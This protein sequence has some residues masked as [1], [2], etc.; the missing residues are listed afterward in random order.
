L[1]GGIQGGIEHDLDIH[2]VGA[3]VR[4]FRKGFEAVSGTQLMDI[5]TGLHVTN[6]YEGR[7]SDYDSKVQL[8]VLVNQLD[9]EGEAC[10]NSW[11]QT[12]TH[13]IARE[14]HHDRVEA[15]ITGIPVSTERDCTMQFAVMSTVRLAEGSPVTVHDYRYSNYAILMY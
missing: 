2:Y 14:V 13:L 10:G 6:N 7:A 12:S 3:Y 1:R 5:Y 11:T 8:I 4:P 15:T 9:A